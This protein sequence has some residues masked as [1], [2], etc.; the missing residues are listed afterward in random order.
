MTLAVAPNPPAPP[1][2]GTIIYLA[3]YLLKLALKGEITP[4]DTPNMYGAGIQVQG[5]TGEMDLDPLLGPR[6]FPGKAQFPLRRQELPIVNSPSELP[7][8][9]TN[10]T[11]DIG[12]YWEI[13]TIVD[14]VVTERKSHIWYGTSY[15]IIQ[16]GTRGQPGAIPELQIDCVNETPQVAP[17]YPD[18]TSYME[19]S[20][21]RLQ[22]SWRFHLAVPRGIPGPPGPIATMPDVDLVAPGVPASGD[23]FACTG[24]FDGQG[25]AIWG[26]LSPRQFATQFFS[27]PQSAFSAYS[28]FD[29]RPQI[30]TFTIPAMPFRYT[31]IVWG[32]LGAG[33]L[34]LSANPLMIGAEVWIGDPD[35][36]GVLVSRGLGNALGEV[37]IMPHYSSPAAPSRNISATNHVALVSAG[38][39]CTLNFDLWNEGQLGTYNFNPTNA[40]L[41]VLVQPMERGVAIAPFDA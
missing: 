8:N 12:K 28:G 21:G 14:G 2:P 23:I 32:H 39:T 3:S 40:Q 17:T 22:P 13:D 15:R 20:G 36:G 26:P 7:S 5:D 37:N 25:R 41:M 6:G 10:T 35:D 38:D 18:T 33:G 27:V 19:T 34:H 24:R 16:M 29:Q 30:G 1:P 9:L 31:P 4:P 11:T